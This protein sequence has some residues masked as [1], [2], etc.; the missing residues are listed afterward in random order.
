MPV[1]RHLSPFIGVADT[2]VRNYLEKP[3]DALVV[4]WQCQYWRCDEIASRKE[5][6]EK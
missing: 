4:R 3:T 6:L 2:T 1:D 5:G